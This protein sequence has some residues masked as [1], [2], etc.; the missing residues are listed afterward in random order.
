MSHQKLDGEGSN[1]DLKLVR[2]IHRAI[3]KEYSIHICTKVTTETTCLGLTTAN[4]FLGAI[5]VQVKHGLQMPI[6][7]IM[8]TIRGRR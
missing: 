4:I 1:S 5:R 7:T 6:Q 3:H 2:V 8:G